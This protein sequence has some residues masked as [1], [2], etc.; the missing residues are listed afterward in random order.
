MTTSALDAHSRAV[1]SIQALLSKQQPGTP[2][3][4]VIERALDLAFNGVCPRGGDYEAELL[5]DSDL[6]IAQQL[7]AQLLNEIPSSSKS[8]PTGPNIQ[9]GR[10]YRFLPRLRRVAQQKAESDAFNKRVSTSCL[11]FV[12]PI[13][14]SAPE[15]AL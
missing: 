13:N 5:A 3:Y 1:I 14:T 10:V 15:H 11:L 12:L 2:R 6:I 8:T 7:T 9:R 4:R